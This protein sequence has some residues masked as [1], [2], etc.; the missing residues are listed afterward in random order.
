MGKAACACLFFRGAVAQPPAY[1]FSLES[2]CY[3]FDLLLA[4]SNARLST[5]LR[6]VPL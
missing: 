5:W 6:A 2:S 1:P 3:P 4:G